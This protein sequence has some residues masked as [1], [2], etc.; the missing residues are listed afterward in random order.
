MVKK[1][2]NNYSGWIIYMHSDIMNNSGMTF[3][4]KSVSD[5]SIIDEL[6]GGI[7]SL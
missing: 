3:L 4:I 2:T 1:L 5:T 7:R 6:G